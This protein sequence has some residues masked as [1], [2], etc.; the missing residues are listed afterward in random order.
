MSKPKHPS[1]LSLEARAGLM[2]GRH[3]FNQIYGEEFRKK[4]PAKEV[5]E[6]KHWVVS[7]DMTAEPGLTKLGV[8]NTGGPTILIEM[9]HHFGH[10]APPITTALSIART[11]KEAED[12][13]LNQKVVHVMNLGSGPKRKLWVHVGGEAPETEVR[14]LAKHLVRDPSGKTMSEAD[15]KRFV[16]LANKL[17]F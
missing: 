12:I 9:R 15:F 11:A 4:H 16:R 14:R 17:N 5:P 10:G 3:K 6:H 7:P 1:S 2:R 8:T 13:Y